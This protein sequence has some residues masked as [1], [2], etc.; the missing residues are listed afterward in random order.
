M[1]FDKFKGCT[2]R[3]RFDHFYIF[4]FSLTFY[5]VKMVK[6]E[7]ACTKDKI[8][9]KTAGHRG[10]GDKCKQLHWSRYSGREVFAS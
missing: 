7:M 8:L 6:T 2:G 3:I 9:V 1:N 10:V 5:D 4:T